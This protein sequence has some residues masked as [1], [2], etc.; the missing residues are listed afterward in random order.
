MLWRRNTRTRWLG[1]LL[2]DGDSR[3]GR[4]V[5]EGFLEKDLKDE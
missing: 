3:G 5:R 1:A 2:T 4:G